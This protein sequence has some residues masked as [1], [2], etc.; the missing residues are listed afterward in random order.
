MFSAIS[1]A[2]NLLNNDDIVNTPRM[3]NYNTLNDL[4]N[5]YRNNRIESENDDDSTL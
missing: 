2:S 3:S 4:T 5:K 1:N